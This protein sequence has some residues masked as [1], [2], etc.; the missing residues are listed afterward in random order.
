MLGRLVFFPIKIESVHVTSGDF[1][2]VDFI[3]MSVLSSVL[4]ISRISEFMKD[5]H[6]PPTPVG[7]RF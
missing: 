5:F 1:S 2:G 3:S 6:S 7:R 4:V